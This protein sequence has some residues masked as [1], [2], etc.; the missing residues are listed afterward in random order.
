MIWH[1]QAALDLTGPGAHPTPHSTQFHTFQ[2]FSTQKALSRKL[3]TR[4]TKVTPT[5]FQVT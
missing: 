4:M 5:P 1:L 2:H 3:K